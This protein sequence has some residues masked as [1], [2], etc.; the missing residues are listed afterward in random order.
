MEI[1]KRLSKKM[2]CMIGA[3]IILLGFMSCEKSSDEQI[4]DADSGKFVEVPDPDTWVTDDDIKSDDLDLLV[5]LSVKVERMRQEFVLMLSNNGEGNKL[6]CGVGPKTDVGPTIKLFTDMMLKQDEYKAALERLDGTAILKQTSTRGLIKDGYLILTTGQ[7]EAEAEKDKVQDILTK[8]NVYGNENAQ[9]QLYDFYC[10]QEPDYAKKIGATDAKDFFNKLNNGELNRYMLNISHIWRDK[11]ILMADQSNN[12]V[13]DYA[14]TAFTGKAEYVNSAYRVSSKV[15]VAAGE[16]YFTAIDKVAGGYGAKIMELGDAIEK[17]ITKLKLMKKV[18]EGKPDWQ[19]INTYVVKSLADDIKAAISE[20]LGDDDNIGTEL[21][22]MVTEE[23]CDYIVEQCTVEGGSDDSS[24]EAKEKQDEEAKA[25]DLAILNI[26]TDFSSQGKMILITDEST[27]KV[28]VATPTY[29]GHV[30]LATTPGNKIV[31]VIKN[32]GERLTRKVTVVEGTNTVIIKSEQKPYID[33]NPSSFTL[34]DKAGSETAVILTNCKYI[35]LRQTAKEDWC[36]VQLEINGSAGRG[37]HVRV[38]AKAN[39]DSKDRSG[40]FILEGYEE[41]KEDSKPVVT[42]T[43]RF[44]QY[45][46]VPELTP[47]DVTPTALNFEAQGGEKILTLNIKDYKYYGGFNDEA[48]DEWLSVV[49]N[50]NKTLTV[51]AKPND[52]GAERTG[53]VYAFGTDDPNPK[54]LDQVGFKAIPITQKGENGELT[55]EGC[56]ISFYLK[57]HDGY[58]QADPKYQELKHS[59][60]YNFRIPNL[61]AHLNDYDDESQVKWSF[62]VKNI[63]KGYHVN[64]ITNEYKSVYFDYIPYDMFR[65]ISFDI[66]V[67]DGHFTKIS[68]I[69]F[70]RMDR[71]ANGD[72]RDSAEI[73]ELKYKETVYKSNYGRVGHP[74]YIDYFEAS[75]EKG[76]L[77]IYFLR[78]RSDFSYIYSDVEH[79]IYDYTLV[80]DPYNKVELGVHYNKVTNAR[81]RSSSAKDYDYAPPYLRVLPVKIK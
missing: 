68:D 12:A 13:G 39:L 1:M 67:G 79:S 32:N 19:D 72:M 6:F 37:F 57:L 81:R 42:K 71:E 29:D 43:F 21:V 44:T 15:A 73:K 17:K 41:A 60:S 9:K 75:Q 64:A 59:F 7:T 65:S 2:I 66:E 77:D 55:I 54:T 40:T 27:G 58:Y 31:T 45:A 80:N 48:S 33:L 3:I 74:C 38:V 35:K 53:I 36:D 56:G 49:I 10:S 28:N 22:N 46:Y 78:H 62:D 30:S 4:I 5:D 76:D 61:Y 34:E 18:L 11:G 70:L 69:K 26:E 25:A 51:K 20:A 23:I 8:N 24:K 63:G 14:Y 52:T 16:I 47:I 50:D